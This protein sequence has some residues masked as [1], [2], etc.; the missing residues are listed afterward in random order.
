MLVDKFGRSPKTGYNVINVSGVSNEYVNRN[1]KAKRS[2]HF[3]C[4]KVKPLTCQVK[5][6]LILAHREDQWTQ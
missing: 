5:P 3:F 4:E 6:L 2:S 1:G